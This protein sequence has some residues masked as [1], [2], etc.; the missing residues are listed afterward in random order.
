MKKYD[1]CTVAP[2]WLWIDD[3][4]AGKGKRRGEFWK[5][6]ANWN[7]HLHYTSYWSGSFKKKIDD[8]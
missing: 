1:G 7:T 8:Y 4:D 3:F 6:P 2:G 5:E